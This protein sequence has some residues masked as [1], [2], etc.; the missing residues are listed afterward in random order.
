[1]SSFLIEVTGFSG[2]IAYR[3]L[4]FAGPSR[5]R[6]SVLPSSEKEWQF[7][8]MCMPVSTT[9]LLVWLT[10]RRRHAIRGMEEAARGLITPFSVSE[11]ISG[12]SR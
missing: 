10:L 3:P 8:H 11:G 9:R 7:A 4:S 5:S 6:P 1:M 12:T 2:T